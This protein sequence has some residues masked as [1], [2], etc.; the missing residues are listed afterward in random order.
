MEGAS[1]SQGHMLKESRV[2]QGWTC[3]RTPPHTHTFKLSIR[4]EQPV[5][6]SWIQ[7]LSRSGGC[8]VLLTS[9]RCEHGLVLAAITGLEELVKFQDGHIENDTG[10]A[11]FPWSSSLKSHQEKI[12]AYCLLPSEIN[13]AQP[14]R[15]LRRSPQR[16]GLALVYPTVPGPI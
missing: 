2:L 3:R 13:P 16:N 11:H 12:G 9:S 6:L 7:G 5:W 4:W 8:G 15:A 1:L 10:L 14:F